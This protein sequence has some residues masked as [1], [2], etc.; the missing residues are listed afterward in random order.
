[1]LEIERKFLI[2]PNTC[3]DAL[4]IDAKAVLIKQA[5]IFS[6]N[7]KNMR[8]RCVQPINPK[9]SPHA[10]ITLKQNLNSTTRNEFEYAI[11]YQDASAIILSMNEYF[12][13]E[14]V[15]YYVPYSSNTTLTWEIDVFRAHNTG[16]IIAELELPSSDI[17][18]DIPSWITREIT[19]EPQYANASLAKKPFSLWE[20][21]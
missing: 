20:S 13:I 17:H 7:K 11:P 3:L 8:I 21:I 12:L 2:H 10:Y 14:K 19:D 9:G 15:R 6:H 5:Y 18:I 1:M 16:L 4:L